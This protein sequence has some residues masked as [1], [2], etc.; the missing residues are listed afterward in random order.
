[1][2]KS[3]YLDYNATTPVDPRVL[4][5]MQPYFETHF[6]NPAS[7]LHAKGWQAKSAI[8]QAR[9]K[10][11]ALLGAQPS[12]ICFT[13]GSTESNN[14]ALKGLV[15]FLI[16][17]SPNSPPHVLT[18]NVEHA[19]VR[20]PLLYLQKKGLISLDFVPVTSEGEITIEAL[21]KYRRPNTRLLSLIWVH[22]EIGTIQ[23]VP[24]L[25]AWAHRHGIY[26]HTD[27]TQAVGKL[28]MDLSQIPVSLL[29]FSGHKI[30]GP[31][32]VGVLFVRKNNPKVLLR[33]L[34][35][36]G[37]QESLGRSG[38]QN[39][40]GIVGLGK[41]CEIARSEM[42]EDWKKV[43]ELSHSLWTEIHKEFPRTRLNGPEFNRRSPYNLNVTFPGL[44]A[45]DLL[46]RLGSLCVSGGSACSSGN[47]QGN[48]VLVALGHDP[49]D[50]SVTLRVSLGR[51]TTR[52][53]IE[54]AR[55]IIYKSLKSLNFSTSPGSSQPPRSMLE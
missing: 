55:E 13:T 10:V 53:E 35:H 52:E 38:T 24:E 2:Q 22:N 48:P 37:G 6:G 42:D 45:S 12:E 51:M 19:S 26:F 54:M 7:Q 1:M 20:E 3:L 49:A 17:E 16:E 15:D 50:S 18:S 34:L 46:P 8:E 9:E 31:K 33:P 44:A 30:Y 4:E 27:A 5:A 36:G 23:A 14:W 11:A 25:A 43:G 28:K 29:S 39:V 41:A 32:G 40:P 47:L 21:E